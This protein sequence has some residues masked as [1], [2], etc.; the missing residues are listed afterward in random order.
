MTPWETYNAGDAVAVVDGESR[1]VIGKDI[2]DFSS[3]EVTQ[4]MGVKSAEMRAP[5]PGAADEV[6]RRDRFVLI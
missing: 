4:V 5:L 3:H 6:I 2:S 1:K